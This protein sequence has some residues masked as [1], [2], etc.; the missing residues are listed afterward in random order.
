MSKSKADFL[1]QINQI[2]HNCDISKFVTEWLSEYT[3]NFLKDFEGEGEELEEYTHWCEWLKDR[4]G[5]IVQKFAQHLEEEG[6]FPPSSEG[7]H[8]EWEK[9]LEEE[10]FSLSD[11]WREEWNYQSKFK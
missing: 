1:Q 3:V 11:A 10:M 4:H 2:L 6:Q 5:E 7:L 8:K 9:W